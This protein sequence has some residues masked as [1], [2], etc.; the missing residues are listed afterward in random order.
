MALSMME[1]TVGTGS[2]LCGVG[3]D[4]SSSSSSSPPCILSQSLLVADSRSKLT[5]C[6]C[7]CERVCVGGVGVGVYVSECEGVCEGMCVGGCEL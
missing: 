6:V 5:D 2:V 1:L 4:L 3:F 7:V